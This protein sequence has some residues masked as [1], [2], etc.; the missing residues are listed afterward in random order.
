MKGLKIVIDVSSIPDVNGNEELD[1]ADI[2]A[3]L[4][5]H[6]EEVPQLFASAARLREEEDQT[7]VDDLSTP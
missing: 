6:P 3:Y 4:I 2:V 5:A 1:V 7:G